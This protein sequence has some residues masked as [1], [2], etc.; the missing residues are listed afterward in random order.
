MSLDLTFS[1]GG[2]FTLSQGALFAVGAYTAALW[3]PALG[4]VPG[5]LAAA[6]AGA[7]AVG[8]IV[9]VLSLRVLGDYLILVSFAVQAVVS[10][11][12]SNLALTGGQEGLSNIAPLFGGATSLLTAAFWL[13]IL[14]AV[15][16]ALRSVQR[17]AF[18][19]RWLF[20]RDNGVLAQSVGISPW[21]ARLWCFAV[22][23]AVAGLAGL[24]YAHYASYISPSSFDYNASIFAVTGVLLGGGET[25]IGPALGT[26]ALF[27]LQQAVAV[28][29]APA[30]WI[31][32]IQQGI[33]G[34]ILI[35]VPFVRPR[36]LVAQRLKVQA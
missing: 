8:V 19:A 29:P 23:G 22:S 30:T 21:R 6:M 5:Q 24:L 17:S 4:G 1:F 33:Y 18:G 13:A 36:G 16:L 26:A 12:I 27:A 9:A 25:L 20:S 15:F 2:L 35:V 7:A 14:G 31:G 32:P 3:P 34:L 10:D 28:L 11:L